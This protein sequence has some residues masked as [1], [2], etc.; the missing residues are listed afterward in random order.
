M[1][2]GLGSISGNNKGGWEV[3]RASKAALNTQMRSFAARHADD[4]RPLVIIAPGRVRTAM[5]GSEAPLGINDSVPSVVDAIS[6]R[7]GKPDLVFLNYLG[8]TVNW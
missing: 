8:Q 4:I 6:S 3:Y 2:S 5:G 1:S 7:S